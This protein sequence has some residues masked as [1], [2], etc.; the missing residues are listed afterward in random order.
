MQQ[1]TEESA[2]REFHTT[3]HESARAFLIEANKPLVDQVVR[4]FKGVRP[5]DREDLRGAGYFGLTRAVDEWR[6]TGMPWLEF[7]KFKIRCACIDQIREMSWVPKG[8]RNKAEQL[9]RAEEQLT[10]KLGRKPVVGELAAVLACSPEEAERAVAAVRTT[11]WTVLSLEGSTDEDWAR[12]EAVADPD[13]ADPEAK[14][15]LE[16]RIAELNGVLARLPTRL[17]DALEA[18]FLRDE[19][20]KEIARRFGCHESRVS[21]LVEQ[22]LD[23]A[24]ALAHE[25]PLLLG[26]RR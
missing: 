11:E 23:Q 22:A 4:R 1:F 5:A 24:R 14:A 12:W 8:V 13:A 3:R 21:Q 25:R 2:W 10:A 7:A 15:L 6:P 9:E 18:K 16:G 17:R 19:P 20:Q 26:V